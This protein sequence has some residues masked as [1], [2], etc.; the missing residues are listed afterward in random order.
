MNLFCFSLEGSLDSLYEAVQDSSNTEVYSVPTRSRSHAGLLHEHSKWNATRRCSSTDFS[1]ASNSTSRKKTSG[2]VSKS[3]SDNESLDNASCSN[4]PPFWLPARNPEDLL[5]IKNN[6]NEEL[7]SSVTQLHHRTSQENLYPKMSRP[8]KLVCYEE[9]TPN[10]Q[11]QRAATV[12]KNKDIRESRGTT[13]KS[14]KSGKKGNGNIRPR[15]TSK[16]TGKGRSKSRGPSPA[17]AAAALENGV[18]RLDLRDGGA[19]GSRERQSWSAPIEA[20]QVW[21]PSYHTCRRPHTEYHVYSQDLT[22]PPGK[23]WIRPELTTDR[24]VRRDGPC[25]IV[26]SV[27]DM[28]VSKRSTSFGRFDKQQQP[29]VKPQENGTAVP[30]GGNVSLENC[31]PGKQ[32]GLGK[33]M[34]AISMTMRLKMGRKCAKNFAEDMVD[35]PAKDKEEETDSPT[36]KPSDSSESLYSGQSSTSSGG[37]VSSSDGC[38]IRGSLRLEEEVPYAGQFCGRAR[39][40]TDFVPS[41]YDTDSLRLKVGD[42]ISVIRKPP[43]G[44]WTGM[45]NNKVGNF[46]FIYVDML[47]EKEKEDD[48]PKIRP[49]R[50]SKRPR[51]KTLLELLE[52]LQLEEYASSLLLNGYQTVEDLIHLQEKH[53]IELNITDPEHQRKLLAVADVHYEIGGDDHGND[54]EDKDTNDCPRDSGCFIPSECSESRDDGESQSTTPD[55]PEHG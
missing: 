24:C 20:T 11:L 12:T 51:P 14:Q 28:D 8:L 48:T 44:I 23:D 21:C 54:K 33:K 41:P 7:E 4:G 42:I 37:V 13:R 10:Q 38:S 27:T 6:Q 26:R 40:H 45:L 15:N 55:A 43:M 16:P 34:K 47:P 39:V 2:M 17:A 52:R 3:V 9:Y 30:E 5:H 53:L 32:G 19:P 36:D 18:H 46:K 29:T 50:L 22:L 1:Y 25:S 49:Q 35:Q 31:E